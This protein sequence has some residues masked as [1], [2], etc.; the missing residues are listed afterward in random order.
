MTIDTRILFHNMEGSDALEADVRTHVARLGRFSR[1]IA[2]CE[3]TVEAPHHHRHKGNGY[4]VMV[5]LLV[6]G[7]TLVVNHASRRG[8]TGEDCYTAIHAAFRSAERRLKDYAQVRR[9]AVKRHSLP[10][11]PGPA[12][13]DDAGTG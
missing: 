10:G 5:R 8:A 1:D 13:N 2:S 3:V 11:Q 12:G 9:H 4:R 7:D 6:P